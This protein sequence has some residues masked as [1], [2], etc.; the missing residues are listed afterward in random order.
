MEKSTATAKRFT[1]T[2][3]WFQS[4][5]Q[6]GLW[7]QLDSFPAELHAKSILPACQ[8]GLVLPANCGISKQEP[9]ES[10]VHVQWR[11]SYVS[12]PQR[13]VLR[14]PRPEVSQRRVLNTKGCWAIGRGHCLGQA[15]ASQCKVNFAKALE[16]AYLSSSVWKN[17]WKQKLF[18]QIKTPIG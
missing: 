6:M 1:I 14:H 7:K 3:S 13:H 17:S 15:Q 4:A 9:V 18:Q 10:S 8:A 2:Y 12:R 16:E 11:A 5:V